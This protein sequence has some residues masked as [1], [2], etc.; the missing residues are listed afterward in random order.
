VSPFGPLIPPQPAVCS[1]PFDF[2]GPLFSYSC[3]LFVVPKKVKSFAI[4]QIRT[5]CAKYRG[6]AVSAA[7][8]PSVPARPEGGSLWPACRQAGKPHVLSSLP[9]LCGLLALFSALAPFIFNRLQPLFAKCRGVASS[10]PLGGHPG[11]DVP[12]RNSALSASRRYHSPSIC[13]PAC[14]GGTAPPP[15]PSES[16]LAKVYQNK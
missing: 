8:V 10:G 15:T 11:W 3:G 13:T 14:A 7:T 16:T 1:Q 2:V 5:L 6:W 12:P 4:K 9:P